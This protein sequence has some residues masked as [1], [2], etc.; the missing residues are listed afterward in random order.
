MA[1]AGGISDTDDG[2]SLDEYPDH[3]E[4]SVPYLTAYRANLFHTR[5][6][7]FF[8]SSSEPDDDGQP[9]P[10]DWFPTEQDLFFHGIRV[11]SRLRPDLIAEGIGTKNTV[12]VAAYIDALHDAAAR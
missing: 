5:A 10:S 3:D 12:D 1:A 2:L 8:S 11:H 4:F 7:N 9:S 6:A